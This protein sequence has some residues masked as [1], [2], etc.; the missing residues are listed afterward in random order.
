MS[1]F[2]II[3]LGTFGIRMMEELV[4]IEADITILDQHKNLIEK[5]KK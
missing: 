1:K 4:K 3:G 5:F 2:A